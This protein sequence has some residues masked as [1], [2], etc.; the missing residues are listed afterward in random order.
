MRGQE[1]GCRDAEE[2]GREEGE[3]KEEVLSIC[4]GTEKGRRGQGVQSRQEE[5]AK[6]N[7]KKAGTQRSRRNAATRIAFVTSCR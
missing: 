4:R 5:T 7:K 6:L 3:R 1:E 2:N